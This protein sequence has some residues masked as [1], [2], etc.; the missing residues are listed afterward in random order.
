MGLLVTDG[1]IR[2]GY[3]YTWAVGFMEDG[4]VIMGDPKLS[5]KMSYTHTVT[6]PA[7]SDNSGENGGETTGDSS[8]SDSAADSGSEQTVTREETVTKSI[9]T[10]NKARDTSGI[11]LYTNDFNAKRHHR[12]HGSRR[13]R[14]AR[15][16]RRKCKRRSAHWSDHDHDGGK[17]DGQNRSHG[18]A[19][20]QNCFVGQ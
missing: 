20:R 11:Y 5:I 12:L 8:L 13:R 2:S 15:S 19:C 10:V 16:R 18:C 7:P 17:R 1:V 6:E 3:N 14:G 9:Y 4:T